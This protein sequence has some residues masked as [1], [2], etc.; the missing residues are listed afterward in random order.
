[1]YQADAPAP[2]G[3]HDEE[4][5][6]S[7]DEQLKFK[8]GKKQSR[9]TKGKKNIKAN[10]KHKKTKAKKPGKKPVAKSPTKSKK[11]QLL[12]DAAKAK[13]PPANET[14]KAKKAK[15]KVE[16]EGIEGSPSTEGKVEKP[17]RARGATSKD[18]KETKNPRAKAKAKAAAKTPGPKGKA[19]KDEGKGAE[20]K[21]RKP[22]AKKTS[23]PGAEFHSHELRSDGL[24]QELMKFAKQFPEELENNLEK[25]KE[26]INQAMTPLSWTKLMPYWSRNGCGVKELQDDMKTYVDVVSFSFNSSS[27]P[28]RYKLAVAVR[29]A[30]IAA[31]QLNSDRSIYNS[32]FDIYALIFTVAAPY[33][34]IYF[35]YSRHIARFSN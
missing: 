35:T 11:R 23:L 7:R 31:P 9:G 25:L 29:C 27:A 22:R 10:K 28:R 3:E 6:V 16:P 26:A 18:T 14:A 2:D 17:R 15:T 32:I 34:A 13:S 30:E 21:P 20:K 33:N 19:K 1:M 4:D 8:Q 5:Y 24:V 12:L